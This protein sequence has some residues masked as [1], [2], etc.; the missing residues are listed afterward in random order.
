MRGNLRGT[1]GTEKRIFIT[2]KIHRDFWLL[3]WERAAIV[4]Y[5]GTHPRRTLTYHMI[6]EDIV[7][8]SPATVCRVLKSAGMLSCWNQTKQS[9]KG[10]GFHQPVSPHEHWH[11]HIAY[12]GIIHQ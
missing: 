1:H 5:Y 12:S 7:A 10:T 6:D 11:G 3:E 2:V 4:K 8:V 9:L